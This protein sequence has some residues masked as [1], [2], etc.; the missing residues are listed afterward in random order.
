MLGA[1][2]DP[3]LDPQLGLAEV[4]DTDLPIAPLGPS[5]LRPVLSCTVAMASVL[6]A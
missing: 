1:E 3:A 6:C 2:L 5:P 4:P